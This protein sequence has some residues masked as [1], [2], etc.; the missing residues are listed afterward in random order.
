[1]A[2]VLFGDYAPTAS[3]TFSWPR[4]MEQIPINVDDTPYDPLF[5]FGHGL[6]Y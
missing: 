1:V 3:L 2:D 6:T 4:D 5:P